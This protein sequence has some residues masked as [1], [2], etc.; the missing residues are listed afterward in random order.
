M[1]GGWQVARQLHSDDSRD[2]SGKQPQL[3]ATHGNRS[4]IDIRVERDSAEGKSKMQ[5][6]M[7]M[8]PSTSLNVQ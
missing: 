6:N 1:A 4:D 2:D 7:T 8:T 5:S 3:H